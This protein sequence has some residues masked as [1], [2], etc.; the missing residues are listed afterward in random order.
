[1]PAAPFLLR[2]T[3]SNKTFAPIFYPETFRVRKQRNLDRQPNFC[4]GE[5]VSDT[6]SK[7]RAIHISGRMRGTDPIAQLNS[8]ADTSEV[9]D[10]V[11]DGWS[12][13]VRIKEVE[14]ES[15]SGFHPPTDERYWQYTVD[16]VSTGRDENAESVTTG[17][18]GGGSDA[19]STQTT[20]DDQNE[21]L[22][23]Q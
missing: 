13:E 2:S 5:D 10:L 4:K 8:A 22:T 19:F 15:T 3:E 7:N 16:V 23:E 6:G 17:Y 21:S 20:L 1:M 11:S 18:S 9:F 12:G 14:Y